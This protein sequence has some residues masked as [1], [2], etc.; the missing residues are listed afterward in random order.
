[1]ATQLRGQ[2]TGCTS[3]P[4]SGINV[5]NFLSGSVT[6]QNFFFYSNN[7]ET[8]TN[9]IADSGIYLNKETLH[10]GPGQVFYWHSNSTGGPINSA[11]YLG[12]PNASPVNVTVSSRGI[13]PLQ[14]PSDVEGWFQ[15]YT[16]GQ[17]Q[18]VPVP[19]RGHTLLYPQ[20][21]PK[22]AIFGGVLNMTIASP[23]STVPLDVYDIAYK[24][25]TNISL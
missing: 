22:G 12:N 25:A 11:I 8:I 3:V 4:L 10:G 16:A 2:N 23:G 14:A 20:L 24:S 19:A 15:Y 9:Q 18:I 13:M 5:L 7:P 21:V 17:G 6:P 1:M